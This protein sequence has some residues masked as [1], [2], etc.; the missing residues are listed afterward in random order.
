MRYLIVLLCTCLSLSPMTAS[1]QVHDQETQ[2]MIR[3][4]ITL[5]ATQLSDEQVVNAANSS[6]PLMAIARLQHGFSS[7]ALPNDVSVVDAR[8]VYQTA[9]KLISRLMDNQELSENPTFLLN[10]YRGQGI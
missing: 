1:A 9:H 6:F 7:E 10:K 4:L 2:T 3:L 5:D 8:A